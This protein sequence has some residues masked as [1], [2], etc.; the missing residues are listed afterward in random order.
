MMPDNWAF[1]AAA[2]GLAVVVLGWYWR[3]LR[4]RERALAAPALRHRTRGA[5]EAR[6]R[7]ARDPH[8]HGAQA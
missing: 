1:V 5:R 8:S 2:Y 6:A 4:R 7:G 3:R